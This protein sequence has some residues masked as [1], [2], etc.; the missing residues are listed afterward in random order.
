M[1][2]SHRIILYYFFD[3]S[4]LIS[5][6]AIT[7]RLTQMFFFNKLTKYA[8]LE[9]LWKNNF[10]GRTRQ[11]KIIL[12]EIDHNDQFQIIHSHET[13]STNP[14]KMGYLGK[15]GVAGCWL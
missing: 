1:S 13:F 11:Q 6:P 5:E 8:L 14:G 4:L 12:S 10:F 2:N 7:A 3:S 9:N 15:L